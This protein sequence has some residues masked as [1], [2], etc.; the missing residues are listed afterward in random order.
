MRQRVR[1]VEKEKE[2]GKE[3][4]RP[5]DKKTET[6]GRHKETRGTKTSETGNK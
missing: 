2:V 6:E 3:T 1:R 4:D 5:G